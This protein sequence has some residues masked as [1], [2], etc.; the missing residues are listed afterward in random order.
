MDMA[1]AARRW[2]VDMVR[3]L[4]DDG[5]RYEVVDGM[6]LVTPAPS[7][8]HQVAVGEL[9]QFLTS[10][11]GDHPVGYAMV[12]P[13]DIEYD[14]ENMVEPDVF[15]VPLVG[16]RPPRS[17]QEAGRLMLAVEVLSPSTKKADRV[18]KRRLYQQQGVPQYWMVDLGQRRI[19]RWRPGAEHPEI[20]TDALSWQ[21][22]DRHPP[23]VIDLARYFARVLGDEGTG[24]PRPHPS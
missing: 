5:N 18:V 16:D 4:P 1:T 21:P 3:S 24:T 7:W 9:Y 23:L 19:E 17:W 14:N 2:T 22:D 20:V 13:T 15:V 11:L 12:A 6:L 10:Y 8:P